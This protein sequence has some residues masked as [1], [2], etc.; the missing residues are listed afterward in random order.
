MSLNI[1]NKMT[2]INISKDD[3]DFLKNFLKDFHNKIIETNDFSNFEYISSNWIKFILENNDKNPENILNMMEI[4]NKSKFWFTSL[5]GFFYQLGIGCNLNREKALHFYLSTIDN[6]IE[7]DFLNIEFNQ[8]YLIEK[9][10]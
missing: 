4:H 3:E 9:N 10:E 5:I 1:L 2:D 7:N 8:L 6:R